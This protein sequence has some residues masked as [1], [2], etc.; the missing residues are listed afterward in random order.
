MTLEQGLP[1]SPGLPTKIR[2]QI[3]KNRTKSDTFHFSNENKQKRPL[4]IQSII[5]IKYILYL[6]FT[7]I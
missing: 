3:L 4:I 7:Q 6:A 2:H 1:L 5:R